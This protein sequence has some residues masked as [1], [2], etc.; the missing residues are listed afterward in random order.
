MSLT[1]H[2]IQFFDDP[3]HPDLGVH[4][5]TLQTPISLPVPTVGSLAQHIRIVD[6]SGDQTQSKPEYIVFAWDRLCEIRDRK[7]S[8]IVINGQP[9]AH[10]AYLIAALTRMYLVQNWGAHDSDM[11]WEIP[12]ADG[13]HLDLKQLVL[14]SLRNIAPGCWQPIFSYAPRR[15]PPSRKPKKPRAPVKRPLIPTSHDF[16]QLTFIPMLPHRY[17]PHLADSVIPIILLLYIAPRII[18]V[19]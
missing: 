3:A 10:V 9:T 8:A 11:V 2:N 6:S 12:G 19:S 14:L 17:P 1:R 7:Q 15:I 18:V 5:V 16:Q 4:V 13:R